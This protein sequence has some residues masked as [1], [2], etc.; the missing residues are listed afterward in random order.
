[1]TRKIRVP[2]D[3]RY[4]NTKLYQLTDGKGTLT[5]EFTWG[6]WE[7]LEITPSDGDTIHFIQEKDIGRLDNLAFEFYGNPN[8]WW[9]IAHVNDIT[10]QL[11]DME[12]GQRLR[13]PERDNLFS[14]LLGIENIALTPIQYPE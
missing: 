14:I 8:L 3:S 2:F 11:D 12:V 4:Q 7:P 10:N 13:I 5:N 9:V 6:I 1:M